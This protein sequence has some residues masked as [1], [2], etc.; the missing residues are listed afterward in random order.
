MLLRRGC[1]GGCAVSYVW[2]AFGAGGGLAE[3]LA[4]LVFLL[5]VILGAD[6]L[7]AGGS[8]RCFKGVEATREGVEAA[9]EGVEAHSEVVETSSER[10]EKS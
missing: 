7:V 3:I 8:T 9:S 6:L 4:L 5:G 1:G 10:V 2:I